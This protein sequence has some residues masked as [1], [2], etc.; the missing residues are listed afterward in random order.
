MTVD[1]RKYSRF[2]TKYPV[3]IKNGIRKF[4]GLVQ[5]LSARGALIYCEEPLEQNRRIDLTIDVQ[6]SIPLQLKA[7][8][9]WVKES[10]IDDQ[11]YPYS[12]GVKF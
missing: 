8:V 12:A 10:E 11:P 6:E 7:E 4:K 2:S 5:N 9:V 1:N 3:V